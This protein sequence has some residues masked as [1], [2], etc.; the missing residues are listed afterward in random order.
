M[1]RTKVCRMGF[2]LGRE[3]KIQNHPF[4]HPMNNL[5]AFTQVPLKSSERDVVLYSDHML[6][7]LLALHED[8]I[9]QL[10]IERL[11]AAGTADFLTS[12][13]SRHERDAGQLQD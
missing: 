1:R 3:H 11:E 4:L 2:R 6:L 10:R 9:M 7:E 8:M 13:I 12:M 5:I